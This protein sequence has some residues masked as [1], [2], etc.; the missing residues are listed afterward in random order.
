MLMEPLSTIP[1]TPA[2]REKS[3]WRKGLAKA[4][5]LV[6]VA[7]VVGEATVEMVDGPD[8]QRG[9]DEVGYQ[10]GGEGLGQ[11]RI[12]ALGLH[13][14]TDDASSEGEERD[15]EHSHDDRV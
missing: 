11:P 1:P 13:D 4:A 12:A 7:G 15:R 6:D 8:L 2:V 14:P 3:K 5:P 10:T 9:R